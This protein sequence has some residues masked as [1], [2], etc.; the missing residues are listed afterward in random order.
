MRRKNNMKKYEKRGVIISIITIIM[1]LVGLIYTALVKDSVENSGYMNSAGITYLVI[2]AILL[3][4][5]IKLSK[6]KKK[7]DE[8]E[9]IYLDERINSNREKSF[10]LTFTIILWISII[11]EFI[12]TFFL[13]QY[14][15]WADALN[16]FV[17]LSIFIYLIVYY[18][19][20]KK[21]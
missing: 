20:S 6:N 16:V 19:V 4:Y 10:A 18:F 9:N 5:F 2:G 8:Q 12:V 1:G 3:L 17:G 13:R 21:N 14:Q 15:Q 7:S 11:A